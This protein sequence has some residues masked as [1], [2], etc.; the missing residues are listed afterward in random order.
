MGK[1]YFWTDPDTGKDFL[2]QEDENGDIRKSPLK[3]KR[4]TSD[5]FGKGAF[6]TMTRSFDMFLEEKYDEYSKLDFVLIGW[7]R[8]NIED[9]NYIRYFRQQELAEKFKTDQAHISRSLKR[10]VK[11]GVISKDRVKGLY[12]FSPKYVRYI[13]GENGTSLDNA[14]KIFEQNYVDPEQQSL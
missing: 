3:E 9:G 8:R 5:Y 13:F 11:D 14:Q 2:V 4:D 12:I 7:L 6:F 10:L 1:E